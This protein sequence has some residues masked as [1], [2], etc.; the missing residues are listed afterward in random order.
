MKKNDHSLRGEKRWRSAASFCRTLLFVTA[1]TLGL[2]T[3]GHGAES[4]PAP[5]W[6]EQT[7]LAETMVINGLHSTVHY[8]QANRKLEEVLT[9]YRTRWDESATGKTGY[10]EAET[11]PWHVISRLEGRYL[12]TVQAK[13][14]GV[15]SSDGYLAI[16]DLQQ[17]GTDKTS[18]SKLPRMQGSEIINDLTSVDPGQ[19]GRT[20][21]LINSYSVASNSDYYR[22]YYLDRGW[23]QIAAQESNGA[24]VLVFSR[25]GSQA[26]LVIQS[27]GDA[28]QV[29]MNLVDRD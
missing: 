20:V 16:A 2:S 26:H 11:A 17:S 21:M 23:G 10:R 15:F 9:F 18:T 13:A 12:L 7:P 29:V 3:V 6:M 22:D 5:V 24:M 4:I 14:N 1:A 28:T 19:R 8:F 25:D 27:S